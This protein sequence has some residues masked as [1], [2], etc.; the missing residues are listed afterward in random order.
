MN[1]NQTLALRLEQNQDDLCPHSAV[2][3]LVDDIPIYKCLL[4]E[5]ELTFEEIGR[6]DVV[7]DLL[8]VSY[9][10]AQ[11]VYLRAIQQELSQEQMRKFF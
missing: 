10:Q 9:N 1:H 5:A 7:I 3:L 8:N 11:K 4:C 2:Y 6:Q